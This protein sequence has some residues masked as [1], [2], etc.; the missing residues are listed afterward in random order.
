[1]TKHPKSNNSQFNVMAKQI[2][3]R[4]VTGL[5]RSGPYF[6]T[7]ANGLQ[8]AKRQTMDS[9]DAAANFYPMTYAFYIQDDPAFEAE[10][11]GASSS[12]VIDDTILSESDLPKGEGEHIIRKLLQCK[13][14]RY[15][16]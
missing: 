3:L 14:H 9:T 13:C 11:A 6:Y 1:M 8:M 4:V 7:D 10:S 15:W 16:Q 5:D 12:A 2:I